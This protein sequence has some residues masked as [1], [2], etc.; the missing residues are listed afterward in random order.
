MLSF[1]NYQT[2]IFIVL[3]RLD[4]G[5]PFSGI[6]Y[7]IY[8]GDLLQIPGLRAGERILLF[9]D[10]AVVIATGMD[11]GKVTEHYEPSWGSI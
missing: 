6:C 2:E 11:F 1:D 8:N 9:V 7:L 5:D 4:Q 10:D 3:N